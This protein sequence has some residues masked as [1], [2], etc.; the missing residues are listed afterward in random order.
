MQ[1][2]EWFAA[3]VW[4]G[5]EFTSSKHLSLRGYEVFLPSYRERRRWSDRVTVI[6]RALFAGYV[7]CRINGEVLGRVVEVPSVIRF[8]G[9]GNRPCPVAA[10]EI[11]AIKRVIKTQAA[12]EPWP[13]PDLGQ[14]VR[15]EAGPLRGVEGVVLAGKKQH[16]LIVSLTLLQRA[17]AVEMDP[18]WLDGPKGVLTDYAETEHSFDNFRS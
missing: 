9:N 17:V 2:S 18:K 10:H 14:R 13:M 15:I 5:R 1:K 6:N 7:F 3:Q 4:S 12:V 11:D 8:V 16:R